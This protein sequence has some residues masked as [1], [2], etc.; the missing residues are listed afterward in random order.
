M[1]RELFAL[2]ALCAFLMA[3]C[4]PV[5]N[6]EHPVIFR[7]HA[8]SILT[9]TSYKDAFA[10]DGGKKYAVIE[11]NS[12]DKIRIYTPVSSPVTS[13][14]SY[15]ASDPTL[16]YSDYDVTDIQTT[17]HESKAELT[18]EGNGLLWNETGG[19]AK[20]YSVFPCNLDVSPSASGVEAVCSIPAT[21]SGKKDALSI[22]PLTAC[23]TVVSS[24]NGA[25]VDLEFNPAFSTFHFQIKG[26][27][28]C[29]TLT[30][31]SFTLSTSDESAYV[32]GTCNY[33]MDSR[34]FSSYGSSASKSVTVNFDPKPTITETDNTDIF[35][36]TLPVDLT[37]L[38]IKVN[39]TKDGTIVEKNLAL[40]LSGTPLNFDACHYFR[41][42]GLAVPDKGIRFF[43]SPA[44]VDELGDV[45]HT[46]NY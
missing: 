22:M 32:A 3:G 30:L 37:K 1:K 2:L 17:G 10:E 44:N 19:S 12:G 29:G 40:N 14:H 46:I 33:S 15:P 7:V 16:L 13:E 25:D 38:F 43:L 5:S 23:Q 18:Q 27:T 20:F 8:R 6:Q 26:D 42:Y 4:V 21:Q 28:G 9:K 35:I 24:Q 31:N 34:A 39:Y 41:I 11:W 36:F 45:S